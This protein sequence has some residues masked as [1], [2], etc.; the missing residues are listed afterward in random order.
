MT[1]ADLLDW[2]NL[3]GCNSCIWYVKRLSGNDT[4]A[5]G[6]HQA[7]PY[8]PR[9]LLFATFSELE[10][11]DAENPDVWFG[12]RVDSHGVERRIRAVWYNNKFHGGTRNE[13]RL[14][15]FGGADS[16]VLDPES[17]GALTIFAFGRF[18]TDPGIGATQRHR[19]PASKRNLSSPCKRM[20]SNHRAASA[21]GNRWK[22]R[23]T[24]DLR[25]DWPANPRG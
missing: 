4:L 19:G 10:R 23:K 15:G 22:S 6:T 9:K 2:M 1:L 5:N 13:T 24:P 7:G 14:T 21:V 17:T 11:Q 12:L 20:G 16:P 25:P 18:D 8:I 3:Y